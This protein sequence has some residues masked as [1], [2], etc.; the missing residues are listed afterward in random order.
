MGRISIAD[1]IALPL[2]ERESL[3]IRQL[4]IQAA[5]KTEN[6]VAFRTPVIGGVAGR[7]FDHPDADVA[8]V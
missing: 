5:A 7:V 3:A 2:F 4:N 8:K 6:H 1:V